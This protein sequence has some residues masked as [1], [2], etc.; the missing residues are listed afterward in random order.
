MEPVYMRREHLSV[1]HATVVRD[2]RRW[3]HFGTRRV[4]PFPSFSRSF[5]LV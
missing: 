2:E 4:C 1:T 5:I 3:F